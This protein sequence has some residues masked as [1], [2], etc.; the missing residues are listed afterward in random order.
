MRLANFM[1]GCDHRMRR[2]FSIGLGVEAVE[3]EAQRAGGIAG[4][5][6]HRLQHMRGVQRPGAAGGTGGAGDARLIQ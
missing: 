2:R 5:D 4:A 1:G 6:I 3:G